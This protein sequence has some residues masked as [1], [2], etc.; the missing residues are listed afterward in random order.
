MMKG[1]GSVVLGRLPTGW[2]LFSIAGHRDDEEVNRGEGA[3][4]RIGQQRV[5]LQVK[6]T[7]SWCL[8][9]MPGC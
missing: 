9:K 2:D 5:G 8:K 3:I 1:R 4:E 7:T 6:A